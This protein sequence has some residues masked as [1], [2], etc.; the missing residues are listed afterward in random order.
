MQKKTNT[1]QSFFY[2]TVNHCKFPLSRIFSLLFL[3]LICFIDWRYNEMT[4]QKYICIG[5]GWAIK[6]DV[7]NRGVNRCRLTIECCYFTLFL[8]I[9]LNLGKKMLEEETL[10]LTW[11]LS[12][13]LVFL[14]IFYLVYFSY[15]FGCLFGSFVYFVYFVSFIRCFE[16]WDKMFQW[17]NWV[18]LSIETMLLT[19]IL[20]NL[21][22]KVCWNFL[23]Y[24]DILSSRMI[25][26]L[27]LYFDL[28]CSET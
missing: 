19:R 26:T 3:Y 17:I 12:W 24:S 11:D 23:S 20:V 22:Q 14:M 25:K 1:L 4:C 6:G 28:D 18:F 7:V 5:T 16:K 27:S 10:S 2:F 9:R 13:L 15:K 21:M 8:K